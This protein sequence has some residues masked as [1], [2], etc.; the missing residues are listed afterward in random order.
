MS[1]G[2]HIGPT[3]K[4]HL[5]VEASR[6]APHAVV[7]TVAIRI[8]WP[9]SARAPPME[10]LRTLFSPLGTTVRKLLTPAP[11]RGNGNIAGHVR[12]VAHGSGQ[13]VAKPFLDERVDRRKR[14]ADPDPVLERLEPRVLKRVFLAPHLKAEIHRRGRGWW[15][16]RS[17]PVPRAP[18]QRQNPAHQLR[19]PRHAELGEDVQH[20]PAHGFVAAVHAVRDFTHAPPFRE[21]R[22]YPALRRRQPRGRQ[23]P[24]GAPTGLTR[25]TSGGRGRGRDTDT[26]PA[27]AWPP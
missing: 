2:H 8:L 25:T 22:S 1:R 19:L 12:L 16:T 3:N 18:R 10:S 24:C 13:W 23:S 26:E 4:F 5:A 6:H 27:T 17:A 21:L 20:V 15:A 7:H 11:I 9:G 14:R